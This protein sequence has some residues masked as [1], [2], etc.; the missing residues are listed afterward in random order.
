MDFGILGI[1]KFTFVWAFVNLI[2]EMVIQK[3]D[4]MHK[5][6]TR[7]KLAYGVV[8]GYV[9]EFTMEGGRYMRNKKCGRYLLT[10]AV[11]IIVLVG[12]TN[13]SIT[14]SANSNNITT[15][16]AQENTAHTENSNAAEERTIN[17]ETQA[18]T[19]IELPFGLQWGSSEEEC[20]AKFQNDWT[21]EEV[22]NGEIK[23]YT[24]N[25]KQSLF[26]RE[27]S[28]ILNFSKNMFDTM[29]TNLAAL[30]D[31]YLDGVIVTLESPIE[32][33]QDELAKQYGEPVGTNEMES[34]DGKKS[35]SIAYSIPE[36]QVKNI[37]NENQRKA[38][39]MYQYIVMNAYPDMEVGL[40]I[41]TDKKE[42]H[43]N[44][45]F[46]NPDELWNQIKDW[47]FSDGEKYISGISV[48]NDSENPNRCSVSYR[49]AYMLPLL[50]VK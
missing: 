39:H 28:V 10:G 29:P 1:T 23:L 38:Y 17:G 49:L 11:S 45:Y 20:G 30:P 8:F 12:C 14:E 7:G 3:L 46:T 36:L 41:T 27:G 15:L 43:K 24:L 33:I 21:C 9:H 32:E 25:Q 48:A 34:V 13:Q 47:K 37:T 50:N 6:N 19:G 18:I 31:Y 35:V 26:G 16:G 5:E 2:R 44:L 22:A 4:S 40:L 42:E